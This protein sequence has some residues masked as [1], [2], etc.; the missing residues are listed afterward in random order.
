MSLQS[1]MYIDT[2]DRCVKWLK[3]REITENIVEILH[4]IAKWFEHFTELWIYAC[5]V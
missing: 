3:Y 1:I 5:L 2:S 4:V